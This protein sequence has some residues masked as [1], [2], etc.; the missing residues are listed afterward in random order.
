MRFQRPA[1]RALS[2]RIGIFLL[3]FALLPAAD[4]N[5]D[6][7]T[8]ARVYG[9]IAVLLPLSVRQTDG[10]AAWDQ[11]IV[12]PHLTVLGGALSAMV[13]HA[14]GEIAPSA[15][16][17]RSYDRLVHDAT[18][19]FRQRWPDYA[20]YS[21]MQLTDRCVACHARLPLEKQARFGPHLVKRMDLDSL[22]AESKA[23]VYVAIS[24]FT[25]A[26]N[27]LEQR[28]LEPALAPSAAHA[29]GIDLRYLRIG[30]SFSTNTEGL[31]RFIDTYLER[32]DVPPA[33][34]EQWQHWKKTLT[35]LSGSLA[36]TPNLRRAQKIYDNVSKRWAGPADRL[37]A[38]DDLIAAHMMRSYLRL[39]PQHNSAATAE[40]YFKLANIALRTREP[41]PPLPEMEILLAAAINADPGGAVAREAFALLERYGAVHHE[42]LA[43]QNATRALLDMRTLRTRAAGAE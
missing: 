41:T 26:L 29:R 14:E 40:L 1:E 22:A 15:V 23:L 3:A 25:A 42:P 38:A 37:R 17:A 35:R 33:V 10:Q 20:Y 16:V 13:A 11:A 32:G 5:A 9:A 36:T 34:A 4:A 28:L 43:E 8:M 39:N 21:V 7:T 18:L 2:R 31:Q 12:E 6:P 27:A 24:Q 30:L 19:S